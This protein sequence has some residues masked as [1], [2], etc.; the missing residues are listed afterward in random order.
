MANTI[1]FE[2]QVEIPLDLGSLGNFRRWAASDSFPQR[3]RIGYL[4]G[5]IERLLDAR[6][7]NLLFRIHRRGSNGYEPAE[8]RS[9]AYE[10]SAVL[11]AWYRLDRSRSAQGRVVF[12]LEAAERRGRPLCL[13]RFGIPRQKSSIRKVSAAGSVC[14]AAQSRNA[15]SARIT[16]V[17]A[18]AR[19]M[20]ASI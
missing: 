2:D 5:R 12:T 8:S 18:C 13:Y 15:N 20:I 1:V 4:Q 10:H 9:D 14:T 7:Q 11:G 17:S 3:G 16:S 6:G 19:V